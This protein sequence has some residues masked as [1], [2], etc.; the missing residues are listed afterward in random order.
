MGIISNKRAISF[1][2]S[3]PRIS[4]LERKKCPKRLRLFC[5][6]GDFHRNISESSSSPTS[7]VTKVSNSSRLLQKAMGTRLLGVDDWHLGQAADLTIQAL[8]PFSFAG[9]S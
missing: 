3:F 9:P 1:H 4:L 2:S 8:P 6:N 5:F 7:H